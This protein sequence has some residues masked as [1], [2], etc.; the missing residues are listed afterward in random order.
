MDDDVF[1]DDD[2]DDIFGSDDDDIFG[3]D[4][5]DIFGSDDDFDIF[6]QGPEPGSPGQCGK[7][8]NAGLGNSLDKVLITSSN[9]QPG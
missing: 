2:D 7:R 9:T 3:S 6:G 1:G 8:N 4:D 5:D